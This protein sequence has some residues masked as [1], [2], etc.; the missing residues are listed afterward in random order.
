M[1]TDDP[2]EKKVIGIMRYR[3]CGPYEGGVIYTEEE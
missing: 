3:S 1:S 2:K